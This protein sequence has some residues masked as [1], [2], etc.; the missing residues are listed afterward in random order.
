MARGGVF[1]GWSVYLDEGRPTFCCDRFGMQRTHI[2]ADRPL[3]AGDHQV[4][5]EFGYDH[6]ISPEERMRIVTTRQ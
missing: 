2:R 6:V 4:R 5:P 3:S 1:G